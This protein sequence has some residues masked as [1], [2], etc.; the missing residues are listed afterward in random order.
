MPRCPSCKQ[1]L[2]E[3]TE[4]D[5]TLY[6]DGGAHASPTCA[7]P[8]LRASWV[9]MSPLLCVAF[10]LRKEVQARRGE[11]V[12]QHVRLRRVR[13]LHRGGGD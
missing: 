11:V 6:C 9:M 2:T 1:A 4:E 13:E 10:R 5:C 7:H 12:L 8:L 3:A